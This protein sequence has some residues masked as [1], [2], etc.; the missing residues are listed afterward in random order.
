MSHK[1]LVMQ[2]V[3]GSGVDDQVLYFAANTL[4]KKSRQDVTDLSVSDLD[5]FATLPYE[6][7]CTIQQKEHPEQTMFGIRSSVRSPLRPKTK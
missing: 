4:H 2:D 3:A 5:A 7:N 6:L 1:V